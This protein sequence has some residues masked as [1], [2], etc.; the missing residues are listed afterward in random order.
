MWRGNLA[1]VRPALP[2]YPRSPC[3]DGPRLTLTFDMGSGRG[4]IVFNSEWGYIPDG[5]Q[6]R[7]AYKDEDRLRIELR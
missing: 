3:P 6:V 4:S 5:V 2:K 7:I 1:N